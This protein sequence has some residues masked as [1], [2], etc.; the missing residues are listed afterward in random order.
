[1]SR[2]IKPAFPTD[3]VYVEFRFENSLRKYESKPTK[4]VKGE[5]TCNN[6]CAHHNLKKIITNS[7]IGR[8][9]LHFS[10]GKNNQGQEKTVENKS[11]G[12]LS[13]IHMVSSN[14]SIKLS[15]RKVLEDVNSN[16]N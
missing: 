14:R 15:K 13:D 7:P 9:N 11:F 3:N 6:C 4:K 10:K 5:H 1:M 16:K 2:F 12:G 8:C